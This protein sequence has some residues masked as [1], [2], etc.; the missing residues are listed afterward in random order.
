MFAP[1]ARMN[2]RLQVPKK[3]GLLNHMGGGNLGDDATQT[4][5]MHN[6]RKRWPAC[7]IVGLSMNPADTQ[8]RHGIP[9][10]PIR[11]QT[12]GFSPSPI[13]STATFKTKLKRAVSKYRPLLSLLEAAN[14]VAARI[15]NRLLDEPSF[16]IKSFRIARSLDLLIIS[17]GGQLLDSW[18]GPWNFPY[19]IFKWVLLAKLSRAKCYFINVGAGPLA[20]PLAKRFVKYA[21]RFAD[22]VSFRDEQSQSLVGKIG[23][24]GSAHVVSD[25]VYGL[26]LQ[27]S[28]LNRVAGPSDPIVGISPMAYCDPRIYWDPNQVI[29][30]RLLRELALFGAWLTSHNHRVRLFSTD[31]RFDE[32]TIEELKVAL[33]KSACTIKP[34]SIL[35]DSISTGEDLL[36]Q[37]RP[38]EYLVTCR[39]HGVVFAHLMNIPVL[40]L[41]H[42]AKVATLMQDFGLSEYC[43]DIRAFD[44][45]LLRSTFTR[46]V[47]NRDD[48][49]ARMAKTVASYRSAL[50]AQ[51][52]ALFP[53]ES[54]Q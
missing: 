36:S 44:S 26:D 30:Q 42:H 3:I 34:G 28:G 43:L 41:S 53:Q 35:H 39:Y 13:R 38:L 20:H 22:Y 21:V 54:S 47:D 29:Y 1:E 32:Q 5:V 46:L 14:T 7:E 40:A 48:I 11:R 33:K 9:S 24:R 17:G 6:I 50:S 45:D 23:F 18:G 2:A 15:R 31:I 51:F 10:Y 49:K 19:T 8:A 4:V 16:L 25:C 52:D 27:E 37:L 12:W